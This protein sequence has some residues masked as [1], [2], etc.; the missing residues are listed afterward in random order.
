MREKFLAYFH[1]LNGIESEKTNIDLV[2]DV[3]TFW[4]GEGQPRKT[5]KFY[6]RATGVS[7][8]LQELAKWKKDEIVY[9][10]RISQ[11]NKDFRCFHWHQ[12]FR[13]LQPKPSLI[14]VDNALSEGDWR[15]IGTVKEFDNWLKF[16]SLDYRIFSASAILF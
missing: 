16:L 13:G 15:S 9:V 5:Q 8:I 1:A 2:N 7:T 6:A 10:G 4:Q 12:S 3:F 14:V 11:R